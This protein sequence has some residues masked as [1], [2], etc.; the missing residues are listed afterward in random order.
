M[1]QIIPAIAAVGSLAGGAAAVG[2][3]VDQASK[4]SGPPATGVNPADAQPDAYY[5]GDAKGTPQAGPT[6][7]QQKA[8][9][10]AQAAISHAESQPAAVDDTT[11]DVIGRP[12]LKGQTIPA[13]QL[14][15]L[16]NDAVKSGY[17]NPFG[18]PSAQDILSRDPHA[19]AV[20]AVRQQNAN[21]IQA[22]SP[23]PDTYADKV[24]GEA[25]NRSNTANDAIGALEGRKADAIDTSKYGGA[26]GS[27]MYGLNSDTSALAAGQTNNEAYKNTLL[28]SQGQGPAADAARAQLQ[29]GIDA[30]N[31]QAM[32]MANS[33]RGGAG[34]LALANRSALMQAALNNQAGANSAAALRASMAQAGIAGLQTLQ[35]QATAQQTA[36][37][38]Q[39][40]ALG[41]SNM[42][43]MAGFA[44]DD[45]RNKIT[46]T[47]VNDS[48]ANNAANLGLNYF[49]TGND[50]AE[51]GV[52]NTI[53]AANAS[54]GAKGVNSADSANKTNTLIK[55]GQA[56]SGAATGA[57]QAAGTLLPQ[58]TGS[59][60][61]VTPSAGDATANVNKTAADAAATAHGAAAGTSEGFNPLDS[62]SVRSKKFGFGAF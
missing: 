60:P 5:H 12:D 34:S 61:T 31:N 42:S 48:A 22:G 54:T 57:G 41:Q 44:S 11:A 52:T 51:Q 1:P 36:L 17:H 8:A 39:K 45:A 55:V 13:G 2:G 32:S 20:T 26:L 59:A 9:Q 43:N 14:T 53:N 46:Q 18:G 28:L 40:T 23:A 47:G 27:A 24:S 4:G 58:D 56:A 19:M 49:K 29:A 16:L 30:S 7:E 33:A 50:V 37:E 15:D 35:G 25:F 21:T 3:A 10:V 62:M 38:A 6:P